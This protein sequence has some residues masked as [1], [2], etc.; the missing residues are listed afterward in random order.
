MFEKI[1]F[2]EYFPGF[3]FSKTSDTVIGL[4][5]YEYAL[6][7]NENLV[8]KTCE[9]AG[10]IDIA[11][12]ADYDYYRFKLLLTSCIAIDK[13]ST[14]V[15]SQGNNFPQDIDSEFI[16]QLPPTIKPFV[17]YRDFLRHSNRNMAS[18]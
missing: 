18:R 4:N 16:Y 15:A 11:T 8:V 12:V 5:G 17:N 13:F 1:L 7:T 2:H 9:Q 3:L 10:Q 6:L 14:A